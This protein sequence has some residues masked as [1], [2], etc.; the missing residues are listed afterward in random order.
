MLGPSPRS[1]PPCRTVHHPVVLARQPAPLPSSLHSRSPLLSS[2]CTPGPP[3][4]A[5]RGPGAT[6]MLRTPAQGEHRA[7]AVDGSDCQTG[8][9]LAAPESSGVGL[10]H[11]VLY[12]PPSASCGPPHCPALGAFCGVG[13]TG[14]CKVQVPSLHLK[15]GHSCGKR[16]TTNLYRKP[17][18]HSQTQK[19]IL[20]G[21][22]NTLGHTLLTGT[23][24]Q[25][26]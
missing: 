16:R 25:S 5:A 17:F 24:S 10:G 19:V 3:V 8:C 15:V 12:A 14:I 18:Q 21:C 7:L 23:Q 26:T 9:S 20:L 22:S 2:T 4:P 6:R 1:Q 13:G 11:L